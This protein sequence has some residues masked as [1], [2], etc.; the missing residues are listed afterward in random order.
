M[1]NRLAQR[2]GVQ[3]GAGGGLRGDLRYGVLVNNNIEYHIFHLTFPDRC[4]I[5]PSYSHALSI[6]SYT[7]DHAKF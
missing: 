5:F 3:H 2:S 1:S 7:V 6:P 4:D